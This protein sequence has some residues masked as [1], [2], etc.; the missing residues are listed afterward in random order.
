MQQRRSTSLKGVGAILKRLLK[1]DR[2]AMFTEYTV[3]TGFVALVTLPALLYCGW[4]LAAS[5][6]FVRN[7]VLYPFP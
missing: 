6:G 7:Y 5:F 2:G 1:D 3:V 4:A